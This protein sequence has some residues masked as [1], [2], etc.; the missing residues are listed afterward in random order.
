M[1]VLFF[2]GSFVNK[3]CSRL[4]GYSNMFATDPKMGV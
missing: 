1:D 4:N 3:W 2:G